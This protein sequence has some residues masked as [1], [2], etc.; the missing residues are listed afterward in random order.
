MRIIFVLSFVFSIAAATLLSNVAWAQT[1][2]HTTP[3]KAAATPPAPTTVVARA[4]SVDTP[5]RRFDADMPLIDWVEANNT[6]RQIG[7]WRAYAK[8]AMRANE[9]AKP[10]S[11]Q[12]QSTTSNKS[13]DKP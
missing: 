3:P 4:T 2:Q 11:P 6:V 1:H 5:Y 9:L 10:T 8:E 12:G 13:G 7:G